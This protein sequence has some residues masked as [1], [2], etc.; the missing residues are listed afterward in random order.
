M[1]NCTSSFCLFEM[2]NWLQTK[3]KFLCLGSIYILVLYS[4]LELMFKKHGKS[5]GLLSVKSKYGNGVWSSRNFIVIF[6]YCVGGFFTVN[7]T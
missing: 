7:K 2:Q 3:L 6:F 5:T 4:F 1:T